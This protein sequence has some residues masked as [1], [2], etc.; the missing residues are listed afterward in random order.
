MRPKVDIE[1]MA[2]ALQTIASK[3]YISSLGIAMSRI[4]SSIL[5][6]AADEASPKVEHRLETTATAIHQ[7]LHA[8]TDHINAATYCRHSFSSLTAACC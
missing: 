6:L 2:S 7:I 4:T 5:A 8:A 3:Q 1:E